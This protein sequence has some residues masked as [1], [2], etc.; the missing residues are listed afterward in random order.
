MSSSAALL[1]VGAVVSIVA[2]ENVQQRAPQRVGERGVIKEV[3]VH[4]ITWF[5]VEFVDGKVLAF[6]PSALQPVKTSSSTAKTL[7]AFPPL[8]HSDASSVENKLCVGVSDYSII[9]QRVRICRG[10]LAGELG[11]V[12]KSGNG[13]VQL[14]TPSGEVAKRMHEVEVLY[15]ADNIL[16]EVSSSEYVSRRAKRLAQSIVANDTVDYKRCRSDSAITDTEASSPDVRSVE[17]ASL[18]YVGE[19]DWVIHPQSVV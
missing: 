6:R 8:A 7:L 12:V 1:C 19:S 2:T 15:E 9:N 5:R 14:M 4:P 16:G 17:S 13:W 11:T 3:P 18:C 10:R